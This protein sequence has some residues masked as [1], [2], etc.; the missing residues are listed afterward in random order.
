MI[1]SPSPQPHTLA[2]IF[3]LLPHITS[4]RAHQD[5]KSRKY[6]PVGTEENQGPSQ[7]GHCPQEEDGSNH[8]ENEGSA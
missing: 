8:V 2:S 5:V 6:S 7:K 1:F 4:S 3:H